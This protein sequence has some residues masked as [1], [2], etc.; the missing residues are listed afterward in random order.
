MILLLVSLPQ[1]PGVPDCG[2]HVCDPG[3][4]KQDFGTALSA[5]GVVESFEHRGKLFNDV[6]LL[7]WAEFDHGPGVV[8][9]QS[10]EELAPD[11]EVGVLHTRGFNN[12]GEAEGQFAKLLCSHS[13]DHE[14]RR[15]IEVA[16]SEDR[17]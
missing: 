2:H 13:R 7:G 5:P 12:I 8:F 4:F 3:S 1:C 15:S 6:C 14:D 11:A 16:R 17:P 10:S 9:G